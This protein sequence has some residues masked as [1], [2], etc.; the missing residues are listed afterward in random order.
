MYRASVE[1]RNGARGALTRDQVVDPAPAAFLHGAA[2]DAS[3][4]RLELLD[5]AESRLELDCN[6]LAHRQAR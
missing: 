5:A 6:P 3:L 2:A 1:L 4:L